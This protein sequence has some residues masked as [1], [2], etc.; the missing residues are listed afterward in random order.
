MKTTVKYLEETLKQSS[1][2]NLDSI[3]YMELS[4]IIHLSKLIKEKATREGLSI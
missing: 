1:L 2:T 3:S 4:E